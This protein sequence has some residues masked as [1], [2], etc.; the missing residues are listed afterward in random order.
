MDIVYALVLS[1]F[2]RHKFEE[3]LRKNEEV[4][5]INP[6]LRVSRGILLSFLSV[7]F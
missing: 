6:V 3:R 4:I 7:N 1:F 2:C 5:L